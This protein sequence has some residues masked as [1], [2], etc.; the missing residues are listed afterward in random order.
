MK[1]EARQVKAN[2]TKSTSISSVS[3]GGDTYSLRDWKLSTTAGCNLYNWRELVSFRN[4]KTGIPG[5]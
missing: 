5:D 4:R 1:D 3:C 2:S